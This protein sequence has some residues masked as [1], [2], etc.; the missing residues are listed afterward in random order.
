MKRTDIHRPAAIVPSD[1]IEIAYLPHEVDFGNASFII[2][3]QQRIQA[4]MKQTG[5]LWSTHEHGGNCDVCGNAQAMTHVIFHHVPSNTYVRVGEICASKV[6]MNFDRSAFTHFVKSAAEARERRAGLQKAQ[7]LLADYGLSEAWAVYDRLETRERA[8]WANT[9]KS[10]TSAEK[11][12]HDIVSKFVRYGSI[13]EKQQAFLGKL[14]GDIS[15]QADRM[16]ARALETAKRRETSKYVGTVGERYE[17][18]ARIVFS[19][20]IETEG[21]YYSSGYTITVMEDAQGNSLVWFGVGF[22]AAKG[23]TIT[24]RATVKGHEERDGVKQTKLT[25]C[26]LLSV[27]QV[28]VEQLT[29]GT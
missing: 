17:G 4:H 20:F 1:Y 10:A 21:N 11:L 6:A 15:G 13:S 12:I 14:L 19:K 25:R 9:W 28:A 24:F 2:A 18:E 8:D 27:V 7:T 16:S 23:D 26:K 22:D 5:G 3:Q 29:K